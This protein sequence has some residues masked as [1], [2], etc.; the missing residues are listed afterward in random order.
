M[1]FAVYGMAVVLAP[2]IGPTLG[3][4]L[5]DN[6]DWRWIFFINIPSALFSLAHPIA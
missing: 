5:T 3:D 6:F 2:A 4:G 1:A